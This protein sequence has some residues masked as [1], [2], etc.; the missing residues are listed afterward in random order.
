MLP[1]RPHSVPLFPLPNLVLFPH[2]IQPLPIFETRYCE[3]LLSVM[4]SHRML[5]LGLLKPGWESEYD[6][7]PPVMPVVCVGQ[8]ISHHPLEDGRH[9]ILL[10]GVGRARIL[11]EL[12]PVRSFREVHIEWLE[13]D[14]PASMAEH[15]AEVRSRLVEYFRTRVISASQSAKQLEPL[16]SG[17]IPLGVLADIVAYAVQLGP[18]QKQALL[19]TVNV[20]ERA[21]TLLSTLENS[22]EHHGNSGHDSNLPFPPPFSIN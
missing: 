15:R 12:P 21:M 4:E 10:Q 14:Y 16:L 20:D 18:I 3:M 17:D 19:E 9:N 2:V 8:V 22:A 6:G 7:R 13:D 1:H 5:C 11:E